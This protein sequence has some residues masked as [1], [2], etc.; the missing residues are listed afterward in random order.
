MEN[1][2]LPQLCADKDC[3]GC[4]ACVNSCHQNALSIKKNEE[5]FYR[6]VLDTGKCVGCGLCENRCPVK[7]MQITKDDVELNVFAGWHLDNEIRM[8]SSSGGAFTALAENI[9]WQGGVVY[10][11]AY[12]DDMQIAHVEVKT[13]DGLERLRLSKYAQSCIGMTM[14]TVKE[15]LELGKKVMYVGT[16]CQV[17]GLKSFLRKDYAN[18]LAVDIICHGVP[19]MMFL[20]NY[21]MWLGRKYGNVEHINFR[22]KRKGW[23]DALRVVKIAKGKEKV[24]RGADDNYWVGFNNNNNL[25]YCCYK[26]QFQGFPRIS[27]MTIAD[28]WGIGKTK[29]FGH[30][31]EIEKGVSMI[32]VNNPEKQH[33]LDECCG[34]M[35]IE[36]RSLEE[37]KIGNNTALAE[38][39]CPQSRATI[40][41]DLAAMDYD[42][43]RKKY[44]STSPKQ[45]VVKLFREYL[46]YGIVRFIRIRSQ[47]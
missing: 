12:T 11:A 23:Y 36:Q 35:F 37:A 5:G 19:S 15:H 4:L 27:D 34:R 29:V 47:K 39:V 1:K 44:L 20:Q 46:P 10:G 17:A 8:N 30:K 13:I 18:L 43:F 2:K 31:D 3:T 22:D 38:S 32:V 21:L 9:L 28:F 25:Q 26:C 14:K 42:S 33:Y 40:Y 41:A 24:L 6:P 16:P 45:N 7:S